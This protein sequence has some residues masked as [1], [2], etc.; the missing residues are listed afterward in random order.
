MSAG[1][2]FLDVEQCLVTNFY[3]LQTFSVEIYW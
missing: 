1:E 2:W 3:F